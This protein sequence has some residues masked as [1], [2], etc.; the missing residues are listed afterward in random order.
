MPMRIGGAPA[1]CRSWFHAAKAASIVSLQA[2]ASRASLAVVLGVPKVA[3]NASPMYF[4]TVPSWA[5]T[6]SAIRR[7]KAR[8]SAITSSGGKPSQSRVN[9]LSYLRDELI[10]AAHKE[11]VMLG[12]LGVPHVTAHNR[13]FPPYQ[14]IE[15][16]V[17]SLVY[18]DWVDGPYPDGD[19]IDEGA[20]AASKTF[21][22]GIGPGCTSED[23]MGAL[24]GQ[25]IPPVRIKEVCQGLDDQGQVRC[26]IESV[27]D[28]DYSGAMNCLAGMIQTS[29]DP[30][31]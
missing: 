9:Y 10:T 6:A 13:D 18:R 3:I 19:I 12:I 16:G 30:V 26:C 24:T 29:V 15:G 20:T 28:S 2:I 25:A 7:G 14:P 1:A 4:S 5:N 17:E 11:V 27:C 8:S 31:G 21:E 23:D 22:L